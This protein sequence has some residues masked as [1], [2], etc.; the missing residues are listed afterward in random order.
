MNRLSA[1]KHLALVSFVAVAGYSQA[2]ELKLELPIATAIDNASW[3]GIV[4]PSVSF[5]FGNT[6][7]PNLQVIAADLKVSDYARPYDSQRGRNYRST[8][9]GTCNEALRNA[10]SAAVDNAKAKG[11]NH[12]VVN[13][14]AFL[15][16]K[17][18]DPTR[19]FMCNSGHG[20][21]TVDLVVSYA[22]LP[23][24]SIAAMA[25]ATP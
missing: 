15:D 9:A 8:E 1:A 4:G 20:S 24:S 10:L 12:L 16:E 25:A 22:R 3:R 2:R 17:S 14:S 23:P 13:Y 18:S 21:S 5:E 6:V 11:A 19:F 7:Q